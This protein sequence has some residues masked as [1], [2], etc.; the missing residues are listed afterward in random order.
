MVCEQ[1]T[2]RGRS[3]VRDAA[4]VLGFSRGAGRRARHAERP[5]LGEGHRRRAA[6]ATAGRHRRRRRQRRSATRWCPAPRP[7]RA[8]APRRR[9]RSRCARPMTVGRPADAQRGVRAVRQPERA[10]RGHEGARAH[11]QRDARRRRSGQPL[12][13][14]ATRRDEHT[15][16][17]NPTT[18]LRATERRERRRAR[19]PRSRRTGACARWPRSSKG[20]T[21]SRGIAP[22]TWAAS[23][24]PPSR[25]STVVPIEPASMPG[26][27]VIQWEKDDLDPAGLVKIDL[28]G[29][30]MLTLLQDCLLYI[31]QTRGV[32][33]DLAQLD[34]DDQAVYDDLCARRHDRRVP[35]GE[36]RADEHAAAPQAALLLRSRGRGRAH[37]ARAHPGRDGAP[38]PAAPRRRWSRSRIR[39]RR[40]SRSSSARSACRSSRSR[41]CRWP[42][43][44]RASRRARPT[45]CAARWATSAAASAWRRSARS[46]IDGMAANG[47]PAERRAAHLQPDQRLRR[48]RL[49]R[50]P[51]GELR[52]ARLR[53][54]V[55]ASTTTRPSSLRGDPQRAADGLLR[56]GHAGGGREA[57]RRGGAPRRR[58]AHRSGT[59]TL[60]PRPDVARRAPPP[61]CGSASAAC[62]GSARRRATSWRR[63]LAA[64]ALHLAS[65]TSCGARGSTS[66]GCATSPRRARSTACS[67]TSPTCGGGA[68]RCGPCSTRAR[69]DAGPLAPRRRPPSAARCG[70]AAGDDARR[71][72]RSRLSHDGHLARRPPDV[73]RARRARPQRRAVGASICCAM[74]AT[75]RRWRR[76]GW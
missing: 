41:G 67:R 40:S 11:S 72:H 58:D 76:R 27:T 18:A 9:R 50:E 51:R 5:L 46:M 71:A 28:L 1:I 57:S 19:R 59:R 52:A 10:E 2:C 54:G 48:L 38:V 75:A 31:R 36:P 25:S 68:P 22:S 21:R 23:S 3:A 33:I 29:L 56:A 32:T 30:G 44:R 35:G 73:A 53:V 37:P 6:R 49:S 4:R 14:S 7:R 61:P 70:A 13:R 42:S 47:I 62:A 16:R 55:P 12:G 74:D 17:R 60:E 65:T 15:E 64:A 66:A 26:R 45:S 43:P 20:C 8:R 24:S 34:M 39:I 63:A 69:G